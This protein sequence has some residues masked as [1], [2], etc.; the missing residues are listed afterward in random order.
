MFK[1]S[2]IENNIIN[3]TQQNNTHIESPYK[4]PHINRTDLEDHLID[5]FKLLK[6]LSSEYHLHADN[7]HKVKVNNDLFNIDDNSVNKINYINCF[8]CVPEEESCKV[9]LTIYIKL[10]NG[11][12][13][14][15]LAINLGTLYHYVACPIKELYF[16]TQK[17]DPEIFKK[18]SYDYLMNN[19]DKIVSDNE[20]PISIFD[21]LEITVAHNIMKKL[22]VRCDP[23]YNADTFYVD[24]DDSYCYLTLSVK[25]FDVLKYK[26]RILF[27]IYKSYYDFIRKNKP[28]TFNKNGYPCSDIRPLIFYMAN[29][30]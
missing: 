16:A 10:P 17:V 8:T 25:I 28:S 9:F 3:E 5:Y 2:K 19:F 11:G 24:Y 22:I 29:V 21:S 20:I 23:T 1:K 27:V 26:L 13:E 30:I 7:I 15:P 14:I 6:K 12:F 4:I 18:N